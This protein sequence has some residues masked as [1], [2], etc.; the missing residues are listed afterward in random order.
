MFSIE[1]IRMFSK[2]NPKKNCPENTDNIA[3]Y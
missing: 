2:T 1:I 3:A